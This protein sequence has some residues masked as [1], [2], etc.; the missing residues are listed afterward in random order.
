MK[1]SND[2]QAGSMAIDV[3]IT[4]YHLW[5][6]AFTIGVLGTVK[7]QPIKH[8]EKRFMFFDEFDELFG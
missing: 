6:I 7:Q 3:R 8:F 5:N 2:I 1:Q 4:E